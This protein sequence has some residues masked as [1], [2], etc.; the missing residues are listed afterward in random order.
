MGVFFKIKNG[1]AHFHNG[2][3]GAVV[4]TAKI[5]MCRNPMGNG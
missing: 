3:A 2:E 5:T 4:H 1:F